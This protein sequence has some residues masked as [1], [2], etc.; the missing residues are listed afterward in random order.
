MISIIVE[1]TP[2]D[3]QGSDIVESLISAEDQA[4]QLGR[5]HIDTNSSNRMIVSGSMPLS[6]YME[7]AKLAQVTDLQK[8]QYNAKLLNYSTTI[9]RAGG[10]FSATT[11]VIM[12]RDE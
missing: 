9:T 7:P 5:M 8:G 12:E 1:R 2:A 10:D 4:M 6:V 3:S 11:S